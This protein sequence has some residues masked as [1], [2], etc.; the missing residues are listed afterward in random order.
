LSAESAFSREEP[1]HAFA[2]GAENSVRCSA[3][4]ARGIAGIFARESFG[5]RIGMDAAIAPEATDDRERHHGIVRDGPWRRRSFAFGDTP[6][7]DRLAGEKAFPEAVANRKALEGEER[8]FH[9]HGVIGRKLWLRAHV[10]KSVSAKA[11]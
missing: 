6:L 10:L 7:D 1:G 5:K 8:A 9:A 3:I 2:D 11:R 4:T